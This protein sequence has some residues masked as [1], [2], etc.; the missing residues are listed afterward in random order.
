MQINMF[1]ENAA[2]KYPDKVAVLYHDRQMT[3]AEIEV[4][5]NK[6]ANYLK[7][8]NICRGD[9]VAILYENSF[10]YIVAY[11]AA[12]KIG[13]IEVS[14][15][16]ETTVDALAHALNDCSAK[17]IIAGAKYSRYL[18]PALKKVPR[19]EQV[20][21]GQQDL[22]EYEDIGHCNQICLKEVYDNGK[23]EHPDVRCIDMDLASIVYTSG[24]TS[25]PKGVMLSHRNVISNT[26]S[27]IQYLELTKKDRMMVVLPLY[28]IYGKSLLTTHFYV[29]GSVVLDN[30]FALPQVVL[31]TMKKTKVTGFAGVPSTF[32]ILLKRSA[33]R[34]FEFESLRYVTQ[35]GGS[36]A[37]IIQKKVVEVFAPAKLFVMYGTTE[38]APRLSYLEPEM[39]PLKWGS[40]GKAIPNVDLFVA[41]KSGN[42]LPPGH[43]GEIVARGSNIMVGYWNDPLETAKVM[44][45]G[46]YY[47]G[48]IGKTDK[49]GY[50]YIV[51]R[52][53]DIIKVGG[54]RVSTKEIEDA[55]L[56]IDEIHEVAVIRV[57]DPILG[58]A[59]KAFVIPR[60]GADL[61]PEKIRKALK[62]M[63]PL[64]KQ[65]KHIELTCSIPKNKSGKILRTELRRRH[66]VYVS[67]DEG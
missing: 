17:A 56:R 26:R 14:L 11:F 49:D 7:E 53:K 30:R 51:G 22:S 18:V 1:L 52:G 5:A 57:D 58:E 47:T 61:T 19:L 54:F 9:R 15:S 8:V 31:Q 45:N 66:R 27:I 24:S 3:Y 64:Y 6:M 10:D 40:I 29:G 20:I 12:L 48:D 60:Q 13:A 42:K 63:L 65:P 21:V 38:A 67:S 25:A 62:T 16:T 2:Q 39:L 33:V 50:I 46:L 23:A 59:I 32:L 41:D 4:R 44:R 37:P 55:L 36:M 28:Y 34:E 35:A 43:T